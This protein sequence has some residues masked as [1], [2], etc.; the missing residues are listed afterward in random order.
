[1]VKKDSILQFLKNFKEKTK[2][3]EKFGLELFPTDRDRLIFFLLIL[4]LTTSSLIFEWVNFVEFTKFS[5]VEREFFVE[6][7]FKKDEK[8]VLKLRDK[9][10]FV[11]YSSLK[12]NIRDLRGMRILGEFKIGNLSFLKYLRGAYLENIGIKFSREKDLRFKISAKI[13][14]IHENSKISEFYSALFLATSISPEL[15]KDLT[16]LGIN[17]LVVLSGFH[18]SLILLIINFLSFIFYKP[19]QS[20]FFP[21]RNF[22][23]DSII[24]SLFPIFL[25]LYFL[26]FP[27]SFLRAVGMTTFVL[28]LLDRSILQK[29]FETLFFVAIFLI[30]ISP[31]LFFSIGFWLSISGVFYIFL[32]FQIFRLKKFLNFLFFN[33]WVFFSMIPII[34]Y[35]FPEFYF[36]QLFSPIWTVLFIFF[37]PIAIL[38]H[39][40]GF[41]KVLDSFLIKFLEIGVYE[42]PK[43]FYTDLYLLSFYILF[44][45][46]LFVKTKSE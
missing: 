23:R 1:V 34:H 11:F 44:S 35:I 19:I 29:P 20:R 45:M 15:R 30:A 10:G 27:P 46:F 38:I 17:H 36:T 33:F 2:A 24:F 26:D 41:P 14:D 21:Y 3:S 40:F 16:R 31:R 13:S 43:I 42:T 25:Y 32:Y 37:Y 22:Y 12:E 28:F 18:V 39:L 5:K 9:S 7:Q 6:N 8:I 4:I